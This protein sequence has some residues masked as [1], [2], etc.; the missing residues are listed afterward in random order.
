MRW[1]FWSNP[2]AERVVD[3][4][5]GSDS[6]IHRKIASDDHGVELRRPPIATDAERGETDRR[7]YNQQSNQDAAGTRDAHGGPA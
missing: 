7:R 3:S 5:R 6:T 1:A 4:G 2:L